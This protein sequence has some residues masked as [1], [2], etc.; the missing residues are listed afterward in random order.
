MR[1]PS[2]KNLIAAVETIAKKPPVIPPPPKPE[3]KPQQTTVPPLRDSE[4]VYI[5]KL[6]PE[7]RENNRSRLIL[8]LVSNND[9][10]TM[11][12]IRLKPGMMIK[13]TNM[14]QTVEDMR[15]ENEER[16]NAKK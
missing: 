11:P 1:T 7:Y 16:R 13:I 14:S 10:K 12:K 5:I 8:E 9:Q 15:K 2:S 6:I 3:V 4:I